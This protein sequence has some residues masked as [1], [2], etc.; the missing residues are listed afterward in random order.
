[1]AVPSL[2]LV[3]FRFSAI[4]VQKLV[5]D[6]SVAPAPYEVT[7]VQIC[8]RVDYLSRYT[9]LIK[10]SGAAA[11]RQAGS[12]FVTRCLSCL[13]SR[14]QIANTVTSNLPL[15][16][17]FGLSFLLNFNCKLQVATETFLNNS[18]ECG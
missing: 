3:V 1:M 8:L 7:G 2:Y 17:C 6:T 16:A 11:C 4:Q 5:K 10:S 12:G 18:H 15:P 14:E 9:N 13:E